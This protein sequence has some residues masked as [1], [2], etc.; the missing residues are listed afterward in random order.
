M[1]SLLEEKVPSCSGG[2]VRSVLPCWDQPDS[3]M[4]VRGRGA[5]CGHL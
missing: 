1:D 5:S 2:R 3:A 4:S